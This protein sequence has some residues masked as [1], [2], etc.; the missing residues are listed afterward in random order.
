MSLLLVLAGVL[1]S[2]DWLLG[3]VDESAA[4]GG[5]VGVLSTGAGEGCVCC[6]LIEGCGSAAV[7]VVVWAMLM[8]A[9][10]TNA[11]TV[12]RLKV[13]ETFISLTPSVWISGHETGCLGIEKRANGVPPGTQVRRFWA[14]IHQMTAA[15]PSVGA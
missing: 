3:A 1:V 4:P 12:T 5:A 13:F 7:G 9:A 6:E 8:P 11:V 15:L 2:G 10:A 14:E